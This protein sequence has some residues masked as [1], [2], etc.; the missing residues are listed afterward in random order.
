MPFIDLPDRIPGLRA[1]AAAAARAW[2][3][4]TNAASQDE[5]E[6]M[7]YDEVGGWYGAPP[8]SSSPTCAG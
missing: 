4:I 1:P 3:R 2:Y 8:T 5:A 7:L 6:V